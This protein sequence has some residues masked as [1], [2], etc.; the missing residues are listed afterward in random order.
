A[1]APFGERASRVERTVTVGYPPD[2]IVRAAAA[3]E[4]D[5]VVVGARGLGA[6][7]RLLLGSV[8]EGVL[9]NAER[10]VLIVRGVEP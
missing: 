4:V 9:R 10:S 5:L 3:A 2:E 1:A 8:S 6:L 7:K